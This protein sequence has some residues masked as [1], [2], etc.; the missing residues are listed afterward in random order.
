MGENITGCFSPDTQVSHVRD[1]QSRW[2]RRKGGLTTHHRPNL[3]FHAETFTFPAGML[4]M[5]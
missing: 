5:V 4:V 1:M 2:D 3:I